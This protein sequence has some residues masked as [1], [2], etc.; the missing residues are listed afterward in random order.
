MYEPAERGAQPSIGRWVSRGLSDEHADRQYVIVDAIDGR[1]HYVD[2]GGHSEELT[3]NSIVRV[4]PRSV[5]VRKVDRTI[6]EVAAAHGGRYSIDNHLSHDPPATQ[7]FTEA[8]V[9]R[10]E[11]IRQKTGAVRHAPAGSRGLAP[12]Q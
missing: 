6:T 7:R 1:S 4:T 8:H 11:A 9:K 3:Q 2:I 10:L 5:A 12:R